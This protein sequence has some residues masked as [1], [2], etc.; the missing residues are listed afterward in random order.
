MLP[1]EPKPPRIERYQY[2]PDDP[3]Y[4]ADLAKYERLREAYE[5]ACDIEEHRRQEERD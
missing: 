4:H 5:E 3:D 2:G 1:S